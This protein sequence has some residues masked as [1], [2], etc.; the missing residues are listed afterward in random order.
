MKKALIISVFL[1]AIPSLASS[2]GQPE[3]SRPSDAG[4][5]V[6]GA[7]SSAVVLEGPKQELRLREIVT[8]E[9]EGLLAVHEI[10]VEEPGHDC[11]VG[12]A[13]EAME[14]LR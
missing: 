13:P 3:E 5:L 1:F 9:G 10:E 6:Y 4:P 8:S 12:L 7:R 11:S 14:H 2:G